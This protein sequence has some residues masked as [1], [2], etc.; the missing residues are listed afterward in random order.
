MRQVLGVVRQMA[1]SVNCAAIV[2]THVKK[3]D[4]GRSNGFAGNMDTARG[5]SSQSG[6]SRIGLTVYS[7]QT[8][9][10]TKW[11]FEGES[12]DYVRIDIAKNNLGPKSKEPMWFKIEK[13]VIGGIDGESAAIVRPANLKLKIAVKTDILHNIAKAIA[14]HF[15]FDAPHTT[16]SVVPHLS[17]S[18]ADLLK[19]DSNR[20]R[21]LNTAFGGASSTE[22]L[23]DYGRLTRTKARGKKGTTFTLHPI[24]STP[25]NVIEVQPC[26]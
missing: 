24:T 10:T 25:Q 15:S 3:P 8:T 11:I 13:T 9:D 4:V 6:M 2:V 26:R 23:T 7:P 1:K 20:A 5:A 16:A 22:Y 21:T 17:D 18:D 19:D 12:T 14:G